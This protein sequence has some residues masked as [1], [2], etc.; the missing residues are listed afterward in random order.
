[1]IVS[2]NVFVVCVGV[3]IYFGDIVVVDDDGVVVVVCEEVNVVYEKVLVCVVNEDSKCV[4]FVVGEFG[5]DIYNMWE[6]L[7]VKGLC[8]V[9]YGEE[10]VLW[11]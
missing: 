8:Y 6:C 7:V 3:L 11:K 9:K 5:L 1:M 4:C 2:V 10:N